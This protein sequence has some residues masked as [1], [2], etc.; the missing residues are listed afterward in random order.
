MKAVFEVTLTT[1]KE[2]LALSNMPIVEEKDANEK[3]WRVTRFEP[4]P[5][6]STYLVCC[7]W[8]YDWTS[9]ILDFE[10][11]QPISE[12]QILGEQMWKKYIFLL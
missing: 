12:N 10:C 2:F 1:Q 9:I 5:K 11:T 7:E 6:M 8:I 3:G 4:T